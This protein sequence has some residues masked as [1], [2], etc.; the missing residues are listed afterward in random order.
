MLKQSDIRRICCGAYQENAYLVCPEGRGD[1]FLVDPGDD[2]TALRRAIGESGRSLSAI[3]LTHG[4]F[5]HILAAQPLAEETG[6]AV[7]IH[8]GDAEMLDD[9]A[10]CAYSPE[11]CRLGPPEGL[12]RTL[13]GAEI[14][15]C[16]VPVRV[17]HTPGH[18]KGSVCLL[19]EGNIL[20]S[21]DTLFCAGYG[22][23]DLYGGDDAQMVRSLKR[24]LALPGETAVLPGHGP[25]TTIAA[26]RRR[27]GL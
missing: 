1:A 25:A 12:A 8:A 20:F 6:A 27:Y 14:E 21:G 17:L 18:S 4:H 24:V 19:A 2:L 26:E 16:G 15:A 7:Y 10:K 9:P 5:D 11:V 13:Y 23:T 22:R 3:L